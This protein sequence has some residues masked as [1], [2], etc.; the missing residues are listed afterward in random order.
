MKC[1]SGIIVRTAAVIHSH[2]P[3]SESFKISHIAIVTYSIAG[4]PIFVKRV[5]LEF[6]KNSP[7]PLTPVFPAETAYLLW[8]IYA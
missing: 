4:N 1:M 6:Y 7:R 5:H 3:L 8:G 2:S